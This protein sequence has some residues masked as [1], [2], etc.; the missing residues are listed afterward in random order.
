MHGGKAWRR[1]ATAGY[2]L[3]A[4]YATKHRKPVDS[5]R[6]VALRDAEQRT[7]A[8]TVLRYE[9]DCS[10][11]TERSPLM[12]DPDGLPCIPFG[13]HRGEQL[14]DIPRGYLCEALKWD[15]TSDNLAAAIKRELSRRGL[16]FGKHRDAPL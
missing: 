8:M 2:L 10:H 6:F 5:W 15:R 13:K 11:Y 14:V 16:S 9:P 7:T 3:E 1:A 4:R 12:F